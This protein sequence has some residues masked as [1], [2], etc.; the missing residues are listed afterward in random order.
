MSATAKL[1]RHRAAEFLDGLRRDISAARLRVTL[2][3]KLGRDTPAAVK[4]LAALPEPPAIEAE[5]REP[6]TT[7]VA[8]AAAVFVDQGG[9]PSDLGTFIA[10]VQESGGNLVI[11]MLVRK[12]S[13][14]GPQIEQEERHGAHQAP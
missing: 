10:N 11:P 4:K 2:D 14:A 13:S 1:D 5:E 3:E 8:A 12:V 7:S 9:A 6:E